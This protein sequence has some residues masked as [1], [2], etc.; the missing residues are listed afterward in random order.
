MLFKI[1]KAS[2]LD[3]NEDR[4]PCK[5]A[6]VHTYDN[7]PF[8]IK[9]VWMVEINTLEDLIALRDEV[10]EELVIGQNDWITIYD[11]FIE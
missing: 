10:G 8:G 3:F 7:A 6:F 5:N 4:K 1:A 11:D 9:K 2:R